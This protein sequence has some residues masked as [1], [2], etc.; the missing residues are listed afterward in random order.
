[1]GQAGLEFALI[2]TIAELSMNLLF[3]TVLR[4]PQR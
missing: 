1:M 2:V 4:G 3:K